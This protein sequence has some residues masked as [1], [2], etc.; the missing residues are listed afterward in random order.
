[1][2]IGDSRLHVSACYLYYLVSSHRS[3]N[4]NA[5]TR[6][7]KNTK[8]FAPLSDSVVAFAS[9]HLTQPVG[10]A[11]PC[12]FLLGSLP[13]RLG[14]APSISA[15]AVTRA[16]RPF[17]NRHGSLMCLFLFTG[18]RPLVQA[19]PSFCIGTQHIEQ[20]DKVGSHSM[21]V[22]CKE[23]W[24]LLFT[25]PKKMAKKT[26]CLPMPNPIHGIKLS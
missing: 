12:L 13:A 14:S 3:F 11:G 21:L 10:D 1:M 18:H 26:V 19:I 25:H 9:T 16:A 22:F 15:C 7:E 2:S 5:I 8:R 6:K 23:N 24:R 17:A 4:F 20:I